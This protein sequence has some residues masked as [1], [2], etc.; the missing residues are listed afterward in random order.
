M[1]NTYFSQL[2]KQVGHK[3]ALKLRKILKRL[4]KTKFETTKGNRELLKSTVLSKMVDGELQRLI[5]KMP[6]YSS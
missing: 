1:A 3:A 6:R 2:E 4:I 5:I